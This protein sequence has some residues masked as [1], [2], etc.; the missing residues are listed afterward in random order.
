MFLVFLLLLKLWFRLY[1]LA[2][3]EETENYHGLAGRTRSG[4]RG[5]DR[6]GPILS[7]GS[8]GTDLVPM[9]S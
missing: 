3:D 7:R 1:G 9:F 8:P 2:A 4:T 5:K 6:G